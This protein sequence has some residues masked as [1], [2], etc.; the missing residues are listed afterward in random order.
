MGRK[1]EPPVR[2]KQSAKEKKRGGGANHKTKSRVRG[3]KPRLPHLVLPPGLGS[4]N[5][6]AIHLRQ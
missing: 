5:R 4:K 1:D 2:R 3:P 6:H